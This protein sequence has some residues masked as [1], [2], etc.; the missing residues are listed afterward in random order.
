MKNETQKEQTKT[1][2]ALEKFYSIKNR[3]ITDYESGL[4]KTEDLKNQPDT[5]IA[6]VYIYEY[7]K[8]IDK[9]VEEGNYKQLVVDINCI[10]S[11]FFELS[12]MKKYYD[13]YEIHKKACED[14]MLH[15]YHQSRKLILS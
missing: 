5:D 15:F 4:K 10:L 2:E 1:E 6:L 13:N 8:N 9:Y 3:K 7:C 11:D 14:I 12:H